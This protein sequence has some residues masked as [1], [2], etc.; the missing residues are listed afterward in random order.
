VNRSSLST[1]RDASAFF[2]SS[3]ILKIF[4]CVVRPQDYD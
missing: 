1:D 2:Y 3:P 4:K